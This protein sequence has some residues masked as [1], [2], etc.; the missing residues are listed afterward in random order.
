MKRF[1]YGLLSLFAALVLV[2]ASAYGAVGRV[3][4][5]TGDRLIGSAGVALLVVILM[6]VA[7]HLLVPRAVR[8]W[9]LTFPELF[10]QEAP[11]ARHVERVPVRVPR[12]PRQQLVVVTGA[13]LQGLG[14]QGLVA[15]LNGGMAME[16]TQPQLA[17]AGPRPRARAPQVVE[18]PE[19]VSAVPPLQRRKLDDV[20]GALR[21]MGFKQYEFEP[22]LAGMDP[23]AP[24]ETLLRDSIRTLSKPVAVRSV[25]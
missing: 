12:A 23:T 4:E 19:V 13:D 24:I 1:I 21:E 10:H 2:R 3:I 6:A 15:A 16:P 22:V 20:R 25:S 7:Y 8:K 5:R 14:L 9:L 18:V 17:S 11:K